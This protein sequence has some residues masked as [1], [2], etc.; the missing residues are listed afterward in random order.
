MD[1]AEQSQKGGS[2]ICIGGQKRLE[3]VKMVRGGKGERFPGA[4][5]RKVAGIF[6][7]YSKRRFGKLANNESQGAREVL[8]SR[9]KGRFLRYKG[10]GRGESR[11]GIKVLTN[12]GKKKAHDYAIS[13]SANAQQWVWAKPRRRLFTLLKGNGR[14]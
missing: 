12:I 10:A 6:R 3:A 4:H 1:S 11:Y 5:N 2:C 13:R 7:L 9:E 8:E 14:D